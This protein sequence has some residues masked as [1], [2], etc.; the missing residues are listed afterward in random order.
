MLET[1]MAKGQV[2]YEAAIEGSKRG[3]NRSSTDY[4]A[5]ERLLAKEYRDFVES[6]DD[7]NMRNDVLSHTEGDWRKAY[8]PLTLA[9]MHEHIAGKR[10]EKHA[11]VFLTESPYAVFDIP[12]AQWK[13]IKKVSDKMCRH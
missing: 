4:T 3:F 9:M 8:L 11:R 5:Y 6:I 12:L 1:V 2:I 7:L 13:A 10:A